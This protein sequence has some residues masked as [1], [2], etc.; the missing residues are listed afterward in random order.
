M[1]RVHIAWPWELGLGGEP[2][3]PVG[4]VFLVDDSGAYLTDDDGY[5]II[6]EIDG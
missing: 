4:Y 1:P 5:Y 6:E 3:P 2:E